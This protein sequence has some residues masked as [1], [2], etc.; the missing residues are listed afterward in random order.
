M[1][2]TLRE[3]PA[4]A[5]GGSV[6]SIM[7]PL[8]LVRRTYDIDL[9]SRNQGNASG[10][11]RNFFLVLGVCEQGRTRQVSMNFSSVED[12]CSKCPREAVEVGVVHKYSHSLLL[13]LCAYAMRTS[14]QGI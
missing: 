14:R 3:S 7:L 11:A 8:L 6:N 5:C 12:Y 10:A 13:L 1:P 9:V 4:L 2:S